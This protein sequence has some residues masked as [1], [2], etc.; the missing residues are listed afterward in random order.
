MDW[1]TQQSPIEDE[2]VAIDVLEHV[3]ITQANIKATH[4][5]KLLDVIFSNKFLEPEV[6]A[7]F[8][9][10]FSISDHRALIFE[11]ELVYDHP[12]PIDGCCHSFGNANYDET[13]SFMEQNPSEPEF[14]TNVN[15][16]GIYIVS[17][18]NQRI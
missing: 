5:S 18:N 3:N 6:A 15:Q 13:S 1:F 8:E 14:F 12:K 4:G 2:N 17:R 7:D 9:K 10:E 11:T 16:N